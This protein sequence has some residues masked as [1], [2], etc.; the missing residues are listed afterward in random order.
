M[1]G[2]VLVRFINELSWCGK[3]FGIEDIPVE[4]A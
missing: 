4:T 2:G 3:T 1:K